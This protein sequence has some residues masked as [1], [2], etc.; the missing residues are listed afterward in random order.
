MIVIDGD[1]V[2]IGAE[3]SGLPPQKKWPA[4]LGASRGL[5][6]ENYATNKATA[7]ACLLRTWKI[8]AKHPL[9]Y[10]LLLGQ[11]SQNHE[12][13]EDFERDLRRI[14]ERMNISGIRVCLMT[15]PVEVADLKPYLHVIR[16]C[17]LIYR[18]ELLDLRAYLERDLP[19][20]TWFANDGTVLCH[21]S[22]IG[23]LKVLGYFDLPE[24]THICR[25]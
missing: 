19:D 21:F 3:G 6:V 5:P 1:S 11:W 14:I 2:A 10:V 16:R 20:G 23:A 24:N 17:A 15:P 7:R 12:P 8:I 22:E 9:W 13:I 4:L 25:P 18:T